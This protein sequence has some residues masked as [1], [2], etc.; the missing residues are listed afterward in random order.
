M[1]IVAPVWDCTAVAFPVSRVSMM[2]MLPPSASAPKPVFLASTELLTS[3]EPTTTSM[4][5]AA[6]VMD[7]LSN[8][9]VMTPDV[10]FTP[11]APCRKLEFLTTSAALAA[12]AS[13]ISIPFWLKPRKATWSTI[14]CPAARTLMPFRPGETVLTRPLKDRFR[15]T[16]VSLAPALTVIPF[17]PDTRMLAT[18]P[19]P[20][21]RVMDF[22]TVT[23]PKPAGS[24]ASISPPAAVFDIAPAKVLQGAVRLQGFTS[25][26][27][28]DT[29]V[30]VACANTGVP[31]QL[32][33]NTIN[34]AVKLRFMMQLPC[35]LPQ[36]TAI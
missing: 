9:A 16:T 18:C 20:P 7:T 1:R 27:T 2:S 17:W 6:P 13:A 29:Q 23:A 33:T 15:T 25:S 34:V 4:P 19:P 8:D 32:I 28:P 24:S 31:Q 26:P 11:V 14:S 12:P 5:V 21:S 35:A 3:A 22:V 10:S 30:R 36:P